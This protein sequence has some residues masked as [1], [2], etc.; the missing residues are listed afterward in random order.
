MSIPI[1]I[2]LY[3]LFGRIFKTPLAGAFRT[4]KI[5]GIA[6]QF[7]WRS[8]AKEKRIMQVQTHRRNIR[9][10]FFSNHREW[11]AFRNSVKQWYSRYALHD[12]SHVASSQSA[13]DC[14]FNR[15]S[16][17]TPRRSVE[18]AFWNSRQ[19]SGRDVPRINE[20]DW[21]ARKNAYRVN[22]RRLA[23]QMFENS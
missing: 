12:G 3:Y 8:N 15:K 20:T 21:S 1:T 19:N 14:R 7:E 23:Q 9:C 2:R 11:W 5:F 10:H 16:H 17:N 13:C 6:G 22:R 18:K 4:R